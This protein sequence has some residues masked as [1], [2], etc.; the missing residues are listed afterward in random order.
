MAEVPGAAHDQVGVLALEDGIE[1]APSGQALAADARHQPVAAPGQV[2]MVQHVGQ[3]VGWHP[4]DIV[5]LQTA[6]LDGLGQRLL[7][8]DVEGGARV[9][10][11]LDPAGAQQFHHGHALHES[12]FAADVELSDPVVTRRAP[13]ASQALAERDHRVGAVHLDDQI[14][15]PHV[16]SQLQG[17]GADDGASR[18]GAQARF[19][20]RPLAAIQRSVMRQV[21]PATVRAAVEFLRERLHP[22]AGVAEDQRLPPPGFRCCMSPRCAPS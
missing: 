13:A 2:V 17:G 6:A 20:H 4:R 12:G 15:R 1:V 16:D 10:R 7:P 18:L 22:G 3:Q 9:W 21:Y 14:H 19:G 8:G 11:G 5:R